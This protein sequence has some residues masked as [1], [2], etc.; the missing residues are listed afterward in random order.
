MESIKHQNESASPSAQAVNLQELTA[1][2]GTGPQLLS[3][4]FSLIAGVK[5]K[6]EVVVG[7]AELSVADL[8]GLQAGSLVPLDQLRDAPLVVRLD[9]QAVATGTL[10]VVGDN[11]GVRINE[12]MPVAAAPGK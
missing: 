6:V 5:V 2:G 9:G 4:N 3:G 1:Q 12:L 7:G 11:F 8:F 10:V